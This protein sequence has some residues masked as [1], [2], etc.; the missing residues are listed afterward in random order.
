MNRLG[1][2]DEALTQGVTIYDYIIIGAGTSGMQIAEILTKK[3]KNILILEAQDTE[4]GRIYSES[5]VDLEHAQNCAWIME[6]KEKLKASLIERGAT[7]IEERHELMLRL[8]KD[9]GLTIR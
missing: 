9:F 4:G 3:T 6:N 2:H 8:C 5:I 1:K 7:W